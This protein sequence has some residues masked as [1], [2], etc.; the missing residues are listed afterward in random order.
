MSNNP[1]SDDPL[2][3]EPIVDP[4]EMADDFVRAPATPPGGNGRAAHG[5]P[6]PHVTAQPGA[7]PDAPP[8]T[9]IDAGENSCVMIGPS[10][11]GKTTLLLAIGR[12]CDLPE[13]DSVKLEFVAE[14]QT[15]QLM[16]ESVRRIA[17]G[18]QGPDVTLNRREQYPFSIH[19]SARPSGLL[20]S[21][22]EEDLYIVMS[23][24][25]GET[26]FPEE[27]GFVADRLSG[28]AAQVDAARQAQ[29]LIF[30]VDAANPRGHFLE[31]E[32]PVLFSEMLTEVAVDVEVPWQQRLRERF[33][34]NGRALPRRRR[35][36]LLNVDR[37]LLLLTQTDRLCYGMT[38]ARRFVAM[39]EPVEQARDLL[40]PRLLNIINSSL[41]PGASF[42]VG[43]SSAW[44]FN[45][46]R[47]GPFAG[48]DGRP[49][50]LGSET[51]REVLKRW[52]PYGIR[53]AIYFI[54]TGHCRGTVKRVQ[55]AD[56]LS[57]RKHQPIEFNFRDRGAQA[58]DDENGEPRFG[59]Q[60]VVGRRATRNPKLAYV[61]PLAF[62]CLFVASVA[63]LLAGSAGLLRTTS[64]TAT[65]VTLLTAIVSAIGTISTTVLAWRKDKREA[66]E[67]ELKLAQLE[68][69]SESV[70]VNLAPATSTEART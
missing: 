60:E 48:P 15:A 3:D 39:I 46:L 17:A 37:F 67:N 1:R 2:D 13:D 6:P 25:G 34:P 52:T 57:D 61:V 11:S 69:E 58:W 45:P 42:A 55:P 28:R 21:P 35:K 62:V 43:V 63:A 9:A 5:P 53:D 27:G 29:S 49:I 36:R 44:G 38:D 56:L 65:W 32:L 14:T 19:I 26:L 50:L 59:Q 33:R 18:L 40:G 68:R 41:K 22:V 7:A 47:G 12:A 10:G 51:P 54:A 30:C 64:D 4:D 8:R 66:R 24:I 23:D 31:Q 20:A 70:K 16:R